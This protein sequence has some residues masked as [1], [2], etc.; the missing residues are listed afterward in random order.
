MSRSDSPAS[1]ALL[2]AAAAAVSVL[3]VLLLNAEAKSRKSHREPE[4]RN[5][6]MFSELGGTLKSWLAE[7]F[8]SSNSS[9]VQVLVVDTRDLGPGPGA[10]AAGSRRLQWARDG[11][12]VRHGPKRRHGDACY[13]TNDV[14]LVVG[15][16]CA[17]N[18]AFAASVLGLAR[19][20]RRRAGARTAD[21]A[22]EPLLASLEPA[23][24]DCPEC[25]PRRR[26][27][28]RRPSSRSMEHLVFVG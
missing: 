20:C 4:I 3:L 22:E 26:L 2:F 14:L 19:A 18:L 15:L 16:T 9:A 10:G 5:G 8:S 12:R 11:R 17:V 27:G 25:A 28:G 23:S 7:W 6:N 1:V 21:G 13:G 24:C